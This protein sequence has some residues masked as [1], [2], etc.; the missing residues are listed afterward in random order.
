MLKS[1]NRKL[2]LIPQIIA[3]L[4]SSNIAIYLHKKVI[5]PSRNMMP[6]VVVYQSIYVV[7]NV[8]LLIKLI[9]FMYLS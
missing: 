7:T 5:N 8:Y 1:K 4:K 2:S 6:K 3:D 9:M